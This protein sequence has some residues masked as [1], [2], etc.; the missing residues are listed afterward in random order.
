MGSKKQFQKL[1]AA[2][3]DEEEV[4]ELSSDEEDDGGFN[5]TWARGLRQGLTPSLPIQLN[6]SSSVRHIIRLSS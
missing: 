5:S 4:E 6:L 2:T 1:K 3:G